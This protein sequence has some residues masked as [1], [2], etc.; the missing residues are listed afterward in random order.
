MMEIVEVAESIE[1][2]ANYILRMTSTTIVTTTFS[3]MEA[4]QQQQQAVDP[5]AVW[6]TISVMD[7]QILREA[8]YHATMGNTTLPQMTFQILELH[9]ARIRTEAEE[10]AKTRKAQEARDKRERKKVIDFD[11]HYRQIDIWLSNDAIDRKPCRVAWGIYEDKIKPRIAKLT[12]K[13][14]EPN[15]NFLSKCNALETLR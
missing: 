14:V 4:M 8:V 6:K 2:R 9:H 3:N 11:S 7:P 13:A 10:A 1:E 15:T 12:A 5:N